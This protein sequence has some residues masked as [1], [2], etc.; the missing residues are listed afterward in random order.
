MSRVIWK[1]H[2]VI[3]FASELNKITI[4][5]KFSLLCKL[6]DFLM[7]EKHIKTSL[8]VDEARESVRLLLTKNH[9]VPTAF[10]AGAPV[11]PLAIPQLR[12]R[13]QPYWAPSVVVWWLF[14][15]RAARDALDE[16]RI[17]DELFFFTMRELFHH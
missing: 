1:L 8:A 13:H 16:M 7:G 9:P 4:Q 6:A 2:C 17:R 14:E 15:T 12:I 5:F 11:N 10:R 3:P